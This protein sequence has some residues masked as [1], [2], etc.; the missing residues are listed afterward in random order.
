M[1]WIKGI[2]TALEYIENNITENLTISGIAS[3]INVSAFYFQKG[4]AMLCGYNVGE[5]IRM[6]R[7]SL[8]GSELLSSDIKII[9]LAVKYCY[10]SSDS[11]TKAF[12]RFHGS[13]PTEVRRKGAPLKAFAPLHIKLSLEGGSVME[14]RIEE[15]KAFKVMGISRE[16]SYETANEDIPKY[17]D[18]MENCPGGKPVMGM[19][20][21]CFDTEMSGNRFRYMI[22][23]DFRAEAVTE[24]NLEEHEIPAHIWAVF[25]CTG[26]MPSALQKINRRIFSEW[27][28]TS[29]Y[30]V[31]EGYN[32][33]HYSNAADYKDGTDDPEYYAEVWI[34]IKEK[35]SI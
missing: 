32:I 18:E 29:C 2:E 3:E 5:Y 26:V 11:F 14:Y 24:K 34:P 8:A 12:T 35:T 27:L 13:T 31:S 1:N 21:V 25:P 9:D 19:Y 17:W 33:E 30:E 28:P 16:F 20:G 7:L 15:K 23:D 10:D 22:A 6:R 4:F